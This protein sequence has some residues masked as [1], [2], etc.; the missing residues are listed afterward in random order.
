[1]EKSF[2]YSARPG[3]LMLSILAFA[4]LTLLA[5]L[6]WNVASGYVLLLFIPALLMCLYQLVVTP[7][8]GLRVNKTHWVILDEDGDYMIPVKDIAHLRVS[9]QNKATEATLVLKNGTEVEI[10]LDLAPNPL[11]LIGAATERGIAVR[12]V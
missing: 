10:P 12:T 4:G 6:L 1:M 2:E 8:Y 11:D 5:A 3:S 9:E 7:I